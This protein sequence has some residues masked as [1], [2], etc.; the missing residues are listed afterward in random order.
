M[1]WK[2]FTIQ[3]YIASENSIEGQFYMLPVGLATKFARLVQNENVRPF[4][5]KLFRISRESQQ[6]IQISTGLHVAARHT[7]EAGLIAK[8]NF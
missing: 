5:P 1:L 2:A 6:S 8:S 7:Y 3:R 4:V